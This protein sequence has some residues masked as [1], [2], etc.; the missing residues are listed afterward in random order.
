MFTIGDIY[1]IKYQVLWVIVFNPQVEK[2]VAGFSL[3]DRIPH[4]D[5]I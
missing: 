2:E 1:A 4:L 3:K 5:L